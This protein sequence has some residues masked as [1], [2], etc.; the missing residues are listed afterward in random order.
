[1]SIP[2]E[3]ENVLNSMPGIRDSAI[4]GEP[5]LMRGAVIKA[6]IVR[7]DAALSED[8]VKEVCTQ[9]ACALQD[10]EKGGIRARDPQE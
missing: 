4:I 10:P 7:D 3:V 2:R 9:A 6:F 1:M 5:D 8:E